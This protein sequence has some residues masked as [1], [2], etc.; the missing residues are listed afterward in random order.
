MYNKFDGA[1]LA[2]CHSD[3]QVVGGEVFSCCGCPSARQNFKK[4]SHTARFLLNF[5]KECGGNLMFLAHS[6]DH[7]RGKNARFY[8]LNKHGQ[9]MPGKKTFF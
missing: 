7:E 8:A 3:K 2:S 6:S 5:I 4:G 1:R 9:E